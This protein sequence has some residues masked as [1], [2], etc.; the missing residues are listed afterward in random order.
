MNQFPIKIYFYVSRSLICWT[1]YNLI[2]FVSPLTTERRTFGMEE[3]IKRITKSSLALAATTQVKKTDG[4]L[5]TTSR[6]IAENNIYIINPDRPTGFITILTDHLSPISILEASPITSFGIFLIS[7]DFNK[8]IL[9]KMDVK[10]STR[11][12]KA[13]IFLENSNTNFR[14]TSTPGES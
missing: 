7:I 14:K 13:F 3:T 4:D 5:S 8:I 2:F 11:E 10:N 6:R 1:D 9:W 12:K